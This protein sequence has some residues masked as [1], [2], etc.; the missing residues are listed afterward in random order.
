MSTLTPAHPPGPLKD[1]PTPPLR[2]FTSLIE[3]EL[4]ELSYDAE[5]AGLHY[6]VSNSQSG[7]SVGFCGGRPCANQHSMT[8]GRPQITPDSLPAMFSRHD[9]IT[10]LTRPSPSQVAVSGYSH[11]LLVLLEEVLRRIAG[12][13]VKE[14]RLKELEA[15]AREV[16]KLKFGQEVRENL[17]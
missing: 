1:P 13:K 3:D 6:M 4:S 5:L 12:F 11:K 17:C 8:S 2:L 15:R 16:Q 14:D 7:F 9:S 10:P